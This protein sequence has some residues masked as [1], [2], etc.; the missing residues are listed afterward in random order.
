M[1]IQ[2]QAEANEQ[3]L[4]DAGEAIGELIEHADE[5]ELPPSAVGLLVGLNDALSPGIADSPETA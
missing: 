2:L 5:V 1:I 3:E 4:A